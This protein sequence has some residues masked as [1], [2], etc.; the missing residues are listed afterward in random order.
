[1]QQISTKRWFW[2]KILANTIPFVKIMANKMLFLQKEIFRNGEQVENIE[3][4][5]TEG[6]KL[7]G[8]SLCIRLMT[9]TDAFIVF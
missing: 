7:V 1:L 2:L 9:A 3:I 4:N 6:V 5:P 8:S